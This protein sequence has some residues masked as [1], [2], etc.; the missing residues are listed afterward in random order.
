VKEQREL[1]N[2]G[3]DHVMIQSE[4]KFLIGA[5]VAGTVKWNRGPVTTRPKN[6]GFMSGAVNKPTKTA[7]FGILDGS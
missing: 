4:L 3:T 2:L 1:E 5:K 7:R 6:R